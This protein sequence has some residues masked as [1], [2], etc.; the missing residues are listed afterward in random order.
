LLSQSPP[1]IIPEEKEGDTDE[2]YDML[3]DSIKGVPS[4]LTGIEIEWAIRAAKSVKVLVEANDDEV[5]RK[6]P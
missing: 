5:L 4:Q 2:F 6:H 3:Y 1:L